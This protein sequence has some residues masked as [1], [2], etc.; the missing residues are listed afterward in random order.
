[1]PLQQQKFIPTLFR[2]IVF[3]FFLLLTISFCIVFFFQGSIFE[4]EDI[5]VCR[6]GIL[7]LSGLLLFRYATNFLS[8]FFVL[9]WATG[10]AGV[11]VAEDAF[12]IIKEEYSFLPEILRKLLNHWLIRWIADFIFD[13]IMFLWSYIRVGFSMFVQLTVWIFLFLILVSPFIFCYIGV[14]KKKERGEEREEEI[15]EQGVKENQSKSLF[16]PDDD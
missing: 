11:H 1:M 5:D 9:P 14:V 8:L 15:K 12:F 13:S 16:F 6:E 10:K 3:G 4:K 2:N 7:C